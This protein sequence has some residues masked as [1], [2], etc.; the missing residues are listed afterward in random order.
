[1]LSILITCSLRFAYSWVKNMKDLLIRILINWGFCSHFF[2]K[3]KGVIFCGERRLHE[4]S[5][6]C[7]I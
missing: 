4:Y 2:V 1:M 5:E 3:R 6:M 7:S